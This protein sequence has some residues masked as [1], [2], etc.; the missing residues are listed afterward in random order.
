MS[1]TMKL[2]WGGGKSKVKYNQ[3]KSLWYVESYNQWHN[4][5]CTC[6]WTHPSRYCIELPTYITGKITKCCYSSIVD[7]SELNSLHCQYNVFASCCI[8]Q[9]AWSHTIHWPWFQLWWPAGWVTQA[10]LSLTLERAQHCISVRPYSA[11]YG[12]NMHSTLHYFTHAIVLTYPTPIPATIL[13]SMSILYF[14]LKMYGAIV[15][16]TWHQIMQWLADLPD[17]IGWALKHSTYCE[18]NSTHNESRLSSNR[19]RNSCEGRIIH[20]K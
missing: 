6:N 16:V 8:R 19:I 17:E 2:A 20:W 15:W 13:P 12:H 5:V 14:K 11:L 18:Y 9:A 1:P 4:I 10:S 7:Q 3:T